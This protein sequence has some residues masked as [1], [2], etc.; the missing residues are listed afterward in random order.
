MSSSTAIT[1]K[2]KHIHFIGYCWLIIVT[3]VTRKYTKQPLQ[4][5]RVSIFADARLLTSTEQVLGNWEILFSRQVLSKLL[6]ML[7]PT[8]PNLPIGTENDWDEYRHKQDGHIRN[9]RSVKTTTILQVKKGGAFDLLS[10]TGVRRSN[11]QENGNYED[12]SKVVPLLSGE[13]IV[14]S[15]PYC[16][17]DRHFDLLSFTSDKWIDIIPPLPSFAS[18]FARNER[19]SRL[20]KDQSFR[21]HR[22]SVWR[23]Y[24]LKPQTDEFRKRMNSRKEVTKE[25]VQIEFHCRVVGRYGCESIRQVLHSYLGKGVERKKNP[26]RMTNGSILIVRNGR[27]VPWFRN[28]VVLG[29]FRALH[30]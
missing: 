26:S 4:R 16:I 7:P 14:R 25:R 6:R 2:T 5:H 30:S 15:N 22:I 21:R 3:I 19:D 11:G 13:W 17:T 12:V 27:N 23:D 9:S 8:P 24:F 20:V 29:S 28:R 10:T 18:I 1:R